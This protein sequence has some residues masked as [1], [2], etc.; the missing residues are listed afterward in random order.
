[1]LRD[2]TQ[3]RALAFAQPGHRVDQHAGRDGALVG[4]EIDGLRARGE[5]G[6]FLLDLED[7][8][9]ALADLRRDLED[10]A[11]FLALDGL[12]GVDLPLPGADAGIGELAGD[13]AAYDEQAMTFGGWDFLVRPGD[14]YF[15]HRYYRA[16]PPGRMKLSV[17]I[18]VSDEPVATPAT[19]AR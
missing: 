8:G 4:D 12:E 1:M 11:D 17:R 5:R 10:D 14:D 9:G 15:L 18:A 19:P 2:P 16:A 6:G 3:S 13:V 7:H